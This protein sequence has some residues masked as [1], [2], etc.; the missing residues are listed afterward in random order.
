[1]KKVF[2]ATILYFGLISSAFADEGRG[3]CIVSG[4]DN[5]YVEVTAYSNGGGTGNFVIAN[6]SSKPLM[7]VYVVITAEVRKGISNIYE[8][9][10]LYRGN[11][12]EKV[13][14]YQSRTENFTYSEDYKVIR[15]ISVEVSN[16][17][18]K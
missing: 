11:F 4:T 7:S 2:F 12:T 15:N 13:E 17:T 8:S 18:C 3:S 14:P 5:D 1:M 16:P 6:S 10:T 9:K